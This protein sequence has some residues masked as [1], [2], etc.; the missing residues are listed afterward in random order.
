MSVGFENRHALLSL[1]IGLP[2]AIIAAISI[3]HLPISVYP[4]VLLMMLVSGG[5]A[6][7]AL[8][9]KFSLRRNL[10]TLHSL[11]ETLRSGDYHLRLRAEPDDDVLGPLHASLNQLAEALQQERL[12]SEESRGMLSA[13]LSKIEMTIVVFDEGLHLCAANRAAFR[14]LATTPELAVGRHA[15]AFDLETLLAG[16]QTSVVEHSFPTATGVWRVSVERHVERNRTMFLLFVDDIRSVLRSEELS[17][18]KKLTR[19]LSHEVNNS[20]APIA[21][22]ASVLQEMLAGITMPEEMREDVDISLEMILGR[23]HHLRAFIQRY[24]EITRLP[25]PDRALEDMHTLLRQL[26]LSRDI[27]RRLVM[28]VPE[29]PLSLYIDRG[30]I[31][32][33]LINLIENAHQA[34]LDADSPIMV[35]CRSAHHLCRIRVIDQGHGISN[36]ANLFV[37]FYS[38]RKNGSGIGLVLSRQIA[39]AH[40]GNLTL[41]NREDAR[42]CVA[43]LTLPIPVYARDASV[44][45]APLSAPPPRRLPNRPGSGSRAPSSIMSPKVDAIDASDTRGPPVLP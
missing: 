23:S 2:G 32:Q 36:P 12:R 10:S 11:T 44:S 26:P 20:L 34:S 17:A 19:V 9:V 45:E 14:L 8:Y 3:W 18:W 38:T 33:V 27:A 39:E 13:V 5:L 6:G 7:S 35:D 15:S 37:P 41:M 40:E 22:V 4:R 24:A 28:Q 42:G 25:G 16:P 21:S 29:D 1:C 30:Q 31:E 43:E